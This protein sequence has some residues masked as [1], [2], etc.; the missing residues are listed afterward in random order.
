VLF[1]PHDSHQQSMDRITYVLE[2]RDVG[3]GPT[4]AA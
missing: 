2:L 1:L 3:V 4:F